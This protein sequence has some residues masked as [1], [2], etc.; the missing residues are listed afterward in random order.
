MWLVGCR[1]GFAHAQFLADGFFLVVPTG[2]SPFLYPRGKCLD[3]DAVLQRKSLPGHAAGFKGIKDGFALRP[4]H[5]RAAKDI[6]FEQM[7]GFRYHTARS[8]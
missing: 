5:A 4:G 1:A 7:F 8:I 6:G 3:F 2:E